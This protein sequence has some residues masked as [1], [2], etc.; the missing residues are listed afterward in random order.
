LTAPTIRAPVRDTAAPVAAI[1]TDTTHGGFDVVRLGSE[2]ALEATFAPHV[3]MTCCSLRHGGAELLGER[4]GLEAYA[5]C[6]TTMGMSLMHPWADRLSSWNYSACGAAVRLPVSPLLH[7]DGWGLPVNGVQSRGDAWVLEQS[8]AAGEWSWLEATLPFDSDP[9]QLELFPFPHRLHLRAEVTGCS[10]C[11][12]AEVE[13]TGSLPVPVCFG[14]RVYLRRRRQGG[15]A[16]I[17]LP[18]RRR[19]VTDER[20]LPTGETEPREMSAST[21]GVDEAHEVFAFGADRR[22]TV[23]SDARRLTVES[24]TGFPLAQVRTVARE[25]HIMLEALTA[26][27]DALSR[28]AFPLAMPGQPYRAALRLSADDIS[29]DRSLPTERQRRPPTNRTASSRR[30]GRAVFPQLRTET[31][32]S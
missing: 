12:S 27:P 25:P 9:R 7:T 32:A 26:A 20:L 16:T 29:S 11:I 15:G 6:G 31:R 30:R 13:A 22:V 23:A 3:G 17:V 10:L 18:A 19:L 21:L 2:D 24:L 4:F 5:S 28:N 8:R 1:G 14:Y